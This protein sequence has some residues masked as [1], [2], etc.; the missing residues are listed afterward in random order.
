MLMAFLTCA[1]K[2]SCRLQSSVMNK[3]ALWFSALDKHKEPRYVASAAGSCH[4]TKR[5]PIPEA[6][7][8]PRVAPGCWSPQGVL[9]HRREVRPGIVIRIRVVWVI[10]ASN[11]HSSEHYSF[12]SLSIQQLTYTAWFASEPTEN[13]SRRQQPKCLERNPSYASK[14]K[15]KLWATTQRTCRTHVS[16]RSNAQHDQD[17]FSMDSTRT[18]PSYSWG[19]LQMRVYTISFWWGSVCSSCKR[20]FL[21]VWQLMMLRH[22]ATVLEITQCGISTFTTGCRL[23]HNEESD[24]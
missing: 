2:A 3:L 19:G 5:R 4:R 9:S 17:C 6:P 22:G 23:N 16:K 20:C 24:T 1:P 21:N 11:S 18:S 8:T 10:S 15:I 7:W 13:S 12:F 14:R